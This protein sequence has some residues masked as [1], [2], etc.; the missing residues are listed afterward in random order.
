MSRQLPTPADRP[1]LRP[2][3][4][5]ARAPATRTAAT[6]RRL[7]LLF[8]LTIAGLPA[9]AAPA[10][11][12]PLFVLHS[13]S[14]E[15]PWTRRQH[16]GFIQALAAAG[17]D[18]SALRVEYLDTK[19]VAYTAAYAASMATHLAR[20]YAGYQPRAIY[21]SDDNALAFALTYLTRIFPDTPVF[22]SGV[23]DDSVRARLD[24]ERITGVFE[25]K[26]LAPNLALMRRLVPGTRAVLVVGDDS[27]TFEAIR[28]DLNTEVARQPDIRAQFVS[29]GRIDRLTDALRG[30]PERIVFLTTLGAIRDADGRAL[31]LPEIIAAIV[32]SGQFVVL[33]MEDVYLYPGVLGGYVTS[34][35]RQG[36][37]AAGLVARYLAGTPVR[38]LPAWSCRTT[39]RA[40]PRSPTGC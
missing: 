9:T 24:P 32:A 16:D 21:V 12:A 28:R 7:V 38:A 18:T 3:T 4:A 34:G 17:L 14:Q 27:E 2:R 37:A 39:S 10:R 26:E 25:H 19:R 33:S 1:P 20:K 36:A 40:P 5:A 29:A 15:Y 13:Y 30:R 11:P 22:F 31:A 35:P 8:A 23:N 6:A